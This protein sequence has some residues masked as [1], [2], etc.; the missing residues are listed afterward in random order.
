MMDL[1]FVRTLNAVLLWT[2]V[3]NCYVC[4]LFLLDFTA[5]IQRGLKNGEHVQDGIKNGEH[6]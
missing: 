5:G 3:L 6:A 4:G 1:T 2:G